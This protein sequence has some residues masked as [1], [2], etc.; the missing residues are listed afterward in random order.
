MFEIAE[1]VG[2]LAGL[3]PVTNPVA[4]TVFKAL[5]CLKSR[6]ALILSAHRDA[7]SVSASTVD[8]MRDVLRRRGAPV[9]LI[10]DLRGRTSRAATSA[11]MSH[12][13]IGLVV[14]TGGRGLVR[15]P[16]VRERL[17][18][19]WVPATRRYGWP[20]RYLATAAEMVITGKSFDHGVICGSENHLVVDRSVRELFTAALEA[21]RAAVLARRHARRLAR[22]LFDE[23]GRLRREVIGKSAQMLAETA[24]ISVP[25]DTRVLVVP[26]PRPEIATRSGPRSSTV[27]S[28][29]D[30]DG[31]ADAIALCKDPHAW[32]T[33]GS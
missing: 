22:A 33:C 31:D 21:A 8:I 14:A 12:P 16:T 28:F 26:V 29:F 20:G 3:T 18:S 6:N 4:T 11:L 2:V 5:I 10:Q 15:R 23:H 19:A 24:N 32:T 1:P 13:A 7:A 25:P 27:L 30:V 9:D 17:P